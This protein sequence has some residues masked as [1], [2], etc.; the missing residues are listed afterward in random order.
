M[1]VGQIVSIAIGVPIILILVLL[2]YLICCLPGV[3][4]LWAMRKT[5]FVFGPFKEFII[6]LISAVF[7]TPYLLVGHTVLVL[8]IFVGLVAPPF[9]GT[10][11][12]A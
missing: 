8:P 1:S 2:G 3:G 9:Q 10:V 6:A 11:Q 4:L 5:N 7:F 12:Q